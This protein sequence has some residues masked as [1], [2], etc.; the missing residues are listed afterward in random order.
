LHRARRTAWLD[1]IGPSIRGLGLLAG[2]L[3]LLVVSLLSLRIGWIVGSIAEPDLEWIVGL[4]PDLI[5]SNKLRHEK[6]YDRFAAIA[7]TVFGERAGSAI[8]RATGFLL[9]K[10][11]PRS[12]VAMSPSQRT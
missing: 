9:T 5:L 12:R 2:C 4:Q 8:T 10:L 6:T 7:P 3:I 11:W 1:A